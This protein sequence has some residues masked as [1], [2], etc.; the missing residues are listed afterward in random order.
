MVLSLSAEAFW[1]R[2]EM[3]W[4]HP[5][6]ADSYVV[7]AL[8]GTN[9]RVLVPLRTFGMYK[10]TPTLIEAGYTIRSLDE[11]WCSERDWRHPPKADSYVV[12]ALLGTNPRVLVPLRTFGMYKKTPTLIEAGYTIRSLD[13]GWCSERDW[14]HP[15]KADS[16]VVVALLGTNPRVLVPL[17]TFGMYKKTPTLIEAG[18]TIRSLDEGWCSE[19]DWRHPPKADSYVVV[20]LLGTNPRVLV[21]LRTFGMYK[22]TPTLIEAGYTIRSLDE[23]WCSERDSN[24]H[25]VKHTPLKR[26]CLPFHHLSN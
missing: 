12:V 3:D 20:A 9:P 4:R 19:R 25:A 7:V 5:P 15:P 18:Y 23:G 8:L 16:Y 6:K 21:P 11:G 22:K 10:K 14:R 26:T 13:E 1:Q 24:P 2:L 17:R